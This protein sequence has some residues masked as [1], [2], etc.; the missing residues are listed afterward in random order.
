VVT[1]EGMWGGYRAIHSART[2]LLAQL[3]GSPD[4][5]K[6]AFEISSGLDRSKLFVAVH[7]R[8]AQD[9]ISAPQVG[10]YVRGKFNIFV[11]GEW[12]LRVCAALKQ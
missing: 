4:A 7:M 2:Y 3:M 12:Y 5:L 9:G 1:V 11:P 8:Y 10:E 6:K